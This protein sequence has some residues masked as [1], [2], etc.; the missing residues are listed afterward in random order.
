M[1]FI[2]Y[3]L[4]RIK[5][6]YNIKFY[7][8]L[9]GYSEKKQDLPLFLVLLPYASK[10][11][12]HLVV[13]IVTLILSAMTMLFLPI[14]IRLMVDNGFLGSD[15]GAISQYFL[16][17]ICVGSILAIVSAIRFYI[18]NWL[19]ERIVA[20]IRT[21]VFKHLVKLGA[22]YF[23]TIHSAEVM[24]R[25]TADTTQIKSAISTA[26][27]Q[28][29]RSAIMVSGALIMMFV[30]SLNLSLMVLLVVPIII[31]LLIG[32]GRAVRRLSRSA[33]D[34]LAEAS[35]F[36]AE[37][38]AAIRT[39]LAFNAETTVTSR[40]DAA[41]ESAFDASKLRLIS[42]ARLTALAMFLLTT[43][44]VII[45]WIGAT[46][47]VVGEMTGG[48]LGQFVLYSI[49]A[50]G[51]ISQLSD[52][53]GEIQ[54]AI[55]SSERLSEL[56]TVQPDVK[57]PSKPLALSF[58]QPPKLG[59]VSFHDVSFVYPGNVNN[60]YLKNISFKA[61]P[62]QKF[63]FVG[64]SGAGKSS[65]FNLLLRFYDPSSGSVELDGVDI[66]KI[67]MFDL[68]SRMALVPQDITIFDASVSENIRY[69][70]RECSEDDV[71]KAAR[72][73]NA[74][75]FVVTMKDKYSTKLG[76]HGITLSG[77]QRQRLAIARAILRDPD[78]LLLD[79]ATSALDAESE[80]EIQ[81]A[82]EEAMRDRTTIIITHRLATAQKAD[83]II[84]LDRG[85]I[86]GQGKHE[87]LT[88]KVGLYKRFAE[89]QLV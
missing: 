49:L 67:R 51:A 11:C 21:A 41:V 84:V 78:I 27:S 33:Q 30:T 87:E 86:V 18:V 59:Q 39:M 8:F 24:S 82:L 34:K 7:S 66:S 74:H 64:P 25:L 54:Q 57:E 20:D 29:V 73:A 36:A 9:D 46:M 37:N 5:K 61:N 89:L 88:R 58:I 75:E 45:L 52:V 42:R 10:Y 47:V 62:G 14:A 19:G 35:A 16:L 80:G 3:H 56:L 26:I 77:G 81:H 55:G 17:M 69:G 68:R 63:A 22:A 23:D 50:G 60:F 40:Y 70:F 83:Q 79:E 65:I 1:T 48:Q 2:Y 12:L 44:I 72:I 38:L 53:W 76:E 4:A 6:L 15:P 43:S 32:C 13:A 31:A 71:E 28:A 85:K